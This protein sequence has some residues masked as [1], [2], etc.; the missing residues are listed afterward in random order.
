M[1]WLARWFTTE[2]D[3]LAVLKAVVDGRRRRPGDGAT[4]LFHDLPPDV[5]AEAHRTSI[6][7]LEEVYRLF[8]HGLDAEGWDWSRGYP[9]GWPTSLKDRI[10]ARV[11]WHQP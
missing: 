4:G 1:D 6:S 9:P 2:I 3:T 11:V 7:A 5:Q 10:R 8:H